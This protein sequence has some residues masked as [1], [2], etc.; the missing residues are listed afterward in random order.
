MSEDSIQ[1]IMVKLE[2]LEGLLSQVHTEVKRTNGRV[3][4]LEMEN[5]RHD[6]D[7]RGKQLQHMITASVISGGLLAVLIWFVSQAV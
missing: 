6:G 2:H 1:V 7:R 3:T 4:A 5:A